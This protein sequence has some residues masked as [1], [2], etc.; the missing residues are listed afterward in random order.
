MLSF[1]SGTE[2]TKGLGFTNSA[3]NGNSD[4]DMAL[5]S[6][7]SV[8]TETVVTRASAGPRDRMHPSACEI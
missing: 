4:H 7:I 6:F 1:N 3:T 2:T 5:W 8:Y